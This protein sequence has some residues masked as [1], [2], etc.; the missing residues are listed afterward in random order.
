MCIRMKK[1]VFLRER[2][3]RINCSGIKAYGYNLQQNI[4]TKKKD[5]WQNAHAESLFFFFLNKRSG[6]AV[7]SSAFHQMQ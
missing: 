6:L 2:G 3:F 4:H 1:F 7:M 5:L